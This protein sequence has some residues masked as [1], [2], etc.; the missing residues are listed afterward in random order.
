MKSQHMD[1]SSTI[2]PDES[3]LRIIDAA[4]DLQQAGK[5]GKSIELLLEA[6]QRAPNYAPIH[7][8]LGLAYRDVGRLEEA[9]ARLRQAVQLDPKQTEALQALGLLLAQQRRSEEAIKVLQQHVEFAPGNVVTLRALSNELARARRTEEATALLEKAWQTTRNIEIGVALG[10]YLLRTKQLVRGEEVFREVTASATNPEPWIEWAQTLLSLGRPRDALAP[11]ERAIELAPDSDRAWR[12]R[13]E[14]QAMLRQYAEALQTAE[15][16]LAINEQD[17][18]NWLVKANV[19]FGRQRFD[20][21]LEAARVGLRCASSDTPAAHLSMHSLQTLEVM[22][23]LR[24]KHND[25]ALERLEELRKEYPKAEQ[26]AMMEVQTFLDLD[27]P[28]EALQVL[29]QAQ[30]QGIP[31]NGNLAPLRYIALHLLGRGEEALTFIEPQLGINREP[32]LKIL[33]DLGLSLYRQ[34]KVSV[35]KAIFAQVCDLAP[36]SVQHLL[37]LGFVLS[38]EDEPSVARRYLSRALQLADPDGSRALALADLAYLDLLQG[39]ND[40][41]REKLTQ[42]AQLASADDQAILRVAHSDNGRAVPDFERYPTAFIP[43]QTGIKAN[44]V[45]AELGRGNLA[46]ARLLA[47]ELSAESPDSPWGPKCLGWVLEAES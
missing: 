23:L 3:V 17:C 45:T 33:S 21:A 9:E 16:A 13:A 26:F 46:R 10:R 14:A 38:G 8:L 11:L 19:L 32:R 7:L 47:E 28:A 37:R 12:A 15:R 25:E 43:V 20:D 6:Q 5:K 39:R 36:D 24:L 34:G 2:A 4:V 30:A 35:A 27:R 1:T 40:E 41:A 22:A 31:D 29:N 42:A 44:L 18:R